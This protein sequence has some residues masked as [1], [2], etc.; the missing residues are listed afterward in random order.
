MSTYADTSFIVSLYAPD[1]NSAE[2]IRRFDAVSLP[3]LFTSFGELE[4]A[5]ALQLRVFRKQVE[6]HE[7]RGA[8]NAFRQHVRT[9]TI[10]IHSMADE[11][12]EASLQLAQRYTARLGVRSPDI[13]HVGS[14]LVLGADIFHTFDRNQKK[15]AAAVGLKIG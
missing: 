15:L 2:A 8:Y 3:L 6:A 4:L 5:N 13:L 7:I 11:I 1:A 12:F 14:A 9:G 10:I